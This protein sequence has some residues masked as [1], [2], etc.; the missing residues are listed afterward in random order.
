[1]AIHGAPVVAIIQAYVFRGMRF[2]GRFFKKKLGKKLMV[3]KK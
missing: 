1:M 2:Q 3:L